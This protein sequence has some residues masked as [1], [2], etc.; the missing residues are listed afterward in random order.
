MIEIPATEYRGEKLQVAPDIEGYHGGDGPDD[1]Q[2]QMRRPIITEK[3]ERALSF[4]I[5]CG[6]MWGDS[7]VRICQD[8]AWSM[9]R[10]LTK[11]RTVRNVVM[12]LRFRKI[13]KFI[14]NYMIM[15]YSAVLIYRWN[16]RYR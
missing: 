9:I 13:L 4:G 7:I 11:F 1:M 14:G 2:E 16:L 10:N 12:N 5:I 3:E 8:Q 6:S 15:I